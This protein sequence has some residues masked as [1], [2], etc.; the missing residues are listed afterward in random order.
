MVVIYA[1]AGG[2]WWVQPTVASPF[3]DID[4]HGNWQTDTHLGSSYA[5]LLVKPSFKPA[6][7]IDG[8]PVVRGDVIALARVAARR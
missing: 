3:T 1:F 2:K 7:T 8:L 4:D 5:A 6:G